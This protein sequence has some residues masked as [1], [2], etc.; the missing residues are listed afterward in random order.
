MLLIQ[1]QQQEPLLLSPPCRMQI[2][3]PA[4]CGTLRGR[5]EGCQGGGRG[6]VKV[7]QGSHCHFDGLVAAAGVSVGACS[8]SRPG[9]WIV[10]LLQQYVRL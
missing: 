5:R 6:I 2:P 9:C 3:L 4:A 1:Q 8:S 7:T 10:Q